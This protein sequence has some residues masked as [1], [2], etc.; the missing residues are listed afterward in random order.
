M[1]ILLVAVLG[2]TLGSFVNALV[3]R[4]RLRSKTKTNLSIWHGR[5]MCPNCRHKLA[6]GDL[7]PVLS[8]LWLKGKCRYCHKPISWQY[9]VVELL[10][11]ALF[12]V[13][14]LAWPYSFTSLQSWLLFVFWLIFLVGFVA[15][16]AYDL[17]WML[18]PNVII[19][20]LLYLA[21]LQTLLL[22]SVF[23]G[24]WES[25]VAAAAGVAVLGGLFY[26]LFQLS[27]GRWIGGGD[28]KLGVLLG[29]LVGGPANAL[30]LLFLA[31][32]LGSLYSV[33]LMLSGK[34]KRTS[35]LPFG[36]FLLASGIIVYLCGSSIIEWY[37]R[38]IFLQ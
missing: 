2:L 7:I 37:K 13:S 18:L 8:W 10:T 33:P 11:A 38:R 14:Y 30:L 12:V 22:A 6:A 23:H 32:L 24:G 26:L 16:I 17:R 9:P 34:A 35:R 36:P 27:G 19:Y 25:L 21:A 28:V 15:L 1:K 31:S 20:P 3:W 4:L 29:L 5:S